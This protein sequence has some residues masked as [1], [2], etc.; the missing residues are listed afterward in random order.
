MKG[1]LYFLLGAGVGGLTGFLVTRR[2]DN[3]RNDEEIAQLEA[4]YKDLVAKRPAKVKEKVQKAP[5]TDEKPAEEA[6]KMVKD[7]PTI[8]DVISPVKGPITDYAAKYKSHITREE[9]DDPIPEGDKPYLDSDPEK[10]M[11]DEIKGMVIIS[12]VEWE[13]D[14]EYEKREITY[15]ENDEIFADELGNEMDNMTP[16][17]VGRPNLEKFGIT[18]E[19]GVLYVRSEDTMTDYR[20]NLEEGDFYS[21]EE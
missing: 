7:K 11:T 5:K 2:I 16:D 4:Y 18:G 17:D 15:F 1:L 9:D 21:V 8:R 6:L 12:D 20:I 14:D 19:E 13:E 10:L 3:K